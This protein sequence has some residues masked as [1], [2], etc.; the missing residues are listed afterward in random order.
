MTVN[1][2]HPRLLRELELRGGVEV[3]FVEAASPAWEAGIREGDILL[4][5]NR[6]AVH[7]IDA[8]RKAVSGLSRGNVV[9]ALVSRE[10]GML[11]VALR[12]K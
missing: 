2:V 6:E 9:S 3:M 7:N 11:F 8:Y 10:G 4:A 5:V 12:N 1:S